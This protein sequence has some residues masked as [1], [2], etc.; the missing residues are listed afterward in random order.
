MSE[1]AERGL[2]G[3]AMRESIENAA[4]RKYEGKVCF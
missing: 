4:K 3:W 1:V 2:V